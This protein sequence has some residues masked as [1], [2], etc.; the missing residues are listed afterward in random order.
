MARGMRVVLRPCGG[1]MRAKFYPAEFG[2]VRAYWPAASSV[3]R[4]ERLCFAVAYG[5]VGAG[6]TAVYPCGGG[7]Y[8]AWEGRQG[9]VFPDFGG[10]W[11]WWK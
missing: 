10:E 1:R 3:R 2:R 6:G 9:L 11:W 4:L 7:Y 8:L 5:Y